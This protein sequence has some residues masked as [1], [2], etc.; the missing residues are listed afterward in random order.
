M[1]ETFQD[2]VIAA[3]AELVAAKQLLNQEISTYPG[4]I[5]GCDIQFNHLL[6]ERQKV[7]DAIRSLDE[8]VFVPT[9]RNLTPTAKPESR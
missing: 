5:A 2:C 1:T 7:L 9:P 6:A 3:R 8:T 4:P